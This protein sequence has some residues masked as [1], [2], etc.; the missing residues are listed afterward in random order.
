MRK[1]AKDY[2]N[3]GGVERSTRMTK[4]KKK[5]H[6]FFYS[7]L[8]KMWVIEQEKV[9]LAE[10]MIAETKSSSKREGKKYKLAAVWKWKG[11][12]LLIRGTFVL[13]KICYIY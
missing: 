2:R 10:E 13:I 11:A 12:D 9:N 4:K 8:G 6:F 3:I 7:K 1:K 5:P